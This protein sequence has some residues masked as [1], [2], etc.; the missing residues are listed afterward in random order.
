MKITEVT[1]YNFQSQYILNE[2]WNIL[3]E[4]QKLHISSWETNVWPLVEQLNIL[5]ESQLTIDQIKQIFSNAEKVSVDGGENLTALGKG[6]KATAD[7]GGKIKAEIDK[8]IKQSAESGPVKNMDQQFDK[9][10]NELANKI[11]TLKGGDRILGAVDKW[12]Q[13]A[14]TNPSKS[15]FIIGAMTSLLAFA[16]GGVI[17]GAAIGFFL[18]L[19]NNTLKGD[20]LSAAVGKATTTAAIG[21][22]AGLIGSI[23]DSNVEISKPEAEGAPSDISI[24]AGTNEIASAADQSPAEVASTLSE[25]TKDQYRL[26]LAQQTAEA[27]FSEM[28]DNMI[29][30]M[31]DNII[32]LGNYPQNFKID[33]NG[34]VAR[35]SIYLTPDE[36]L[37]YKQWASGR[38]LIDAALSR[39]ASEWLK[40]NVAGAEEQIKASAL[41]RMES[42]NNL[43]SKQQKLNEG[44]LGSAAKSVGGVAT[45]GAK[46]VGKGV[47]RAVNRGASAVGKQMSQ[48]ITTRTLGKLW[49]DSGSPTDV[50]SIA[51][52][53]AQAGMSDKQIGLVS[54]QTNI[55]LQTKK[56][57]I[58]SLA[59]EIKKAGIADIIKQALTKN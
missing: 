21:S 6:A 16:S 26:Q 49:K 45:A 4:R 30:K 17:S 34:S 56:I 53:L 14:Q 27:R 46:S 9:L 18:R 15:A 44:P 37:A 58:S 42:K 28:S 11:K 33:F 1:N 25:L 12:K 20:K 13:F 24:E 55:N 38:D 10:R 31:A 59:S 23:V 47:A 5:L 43:K 54:Q 3:T 39:E 52:I 40:Q 48:Q 57:D 2:G 41:S 8:L 29:Q 32:I 51:N 22:V 50:G 36:A 7:I 19:A 35:A